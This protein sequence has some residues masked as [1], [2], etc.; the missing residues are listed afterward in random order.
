MSSQQAT[1]DAALD[2][3]ADDRDRRVVEHPERVWFRDYHEHLRMR[4]EGEL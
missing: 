2:R 3:V 1:L 4:R